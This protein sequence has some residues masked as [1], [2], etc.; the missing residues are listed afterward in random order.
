MTIKDN[1]QKIL[2][3]LVPAT[4]NL[5]GERLTAL[6]VFGS[7]GRNTPRPDSD[8]DLL[9]VVKDLPSGRLRRM[10]EFTQLERSLGPLLEE[11]KKQGIETTLSPV[12]KTPDEIRKGSPLFMDM[13]EDGVILFEKDSFF[14]DYLRDFSTRLHNLGARRLRRG[15]SWYWLLDQNHSIDEVIIQ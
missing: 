12:I 5:Y 11:L 15:E 13:M 7:V 9:F 10:D 4:Q 8:I 3:A 1:F 14:S 2:R 6:V